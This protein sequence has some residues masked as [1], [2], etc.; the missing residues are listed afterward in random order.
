M[1]NERVKEKVCGWQH[2]CPSASGNMA[3]PRVPSVDVLNTLRCSQ[4]QHEL[5]DKWGT[6]LISLPLFL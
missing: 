5:A 4:S 3:G 2:R 1:S 6:G